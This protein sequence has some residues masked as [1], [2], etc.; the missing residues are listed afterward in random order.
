MITQII[1]RQFSLSCCDAIPPSHDS[2]IIMG[3]CI[4][5]AV[6][7]IVMWQIITGTSRISGVKRKFQNLHSRESALIY[8]MT[9]GICH[10]SQ[11]LCDNLL[12]SKRLFNLTEQINSGTLFP[13]SASCIFISVW[14]REIFIKSTEMIDSHNIIQSEAVTHSGNPPLISCISVI[15]PAIQRISP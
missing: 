5:H 14:N 4:R 13:V 12:P 11:V 9:Y 1:S 8:Q 3:S 7:R 2:F 15:I 6:L 10:I